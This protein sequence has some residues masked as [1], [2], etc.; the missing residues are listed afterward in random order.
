MLSDPDTRHFFSNIDIEKQRIRMKQY[1]IILMG[2]PN[3]YLGKSIKT[4]HEKLKISKTD[5]DHFWDHIEHAMKYYKIEQ[6]LI[7]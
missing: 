4:A 3:S 7:D 2:G 6:V 1:M 5:F